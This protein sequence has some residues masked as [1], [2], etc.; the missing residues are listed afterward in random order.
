MVAPRSILIAV[1]DMQRAVD[2]YSMLGLEFSTESPQHYHC[3]T[4]DLPLML[5]HDPLLVTAMSVTEDL[6]PNGRAS[7]GLRCE[8]SEEVDAIYE[9]AAAAGFGVT[10]PWDAMWGQRYAI[11]RDP[12]GT[13]VDLYAVFPQGE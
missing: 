13:R 1:S 9:K 11:L 3:T 5:N 4:G 12:D 6:Q 10:P 7:V 8:S 2:F